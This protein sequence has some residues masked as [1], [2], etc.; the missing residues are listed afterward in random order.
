M[1]RIGFIGTGEIAAAMVTGLIG[2]GHQIMVS[3]R[4]SGMAAAL[5]AQSS[6]V[7]I[8]PNEQVVA[9]SD[10]VFLC[11]LAEVARDVL[12]GLPFHAGQSVIS[13][14]ADLPLADLRTLCAPAEELAITIPLAPIAVG[15][16]A[17]PVYPDSPALRALF[18]DTDLIIPC[19]DEAALNAHFGAS[20]LASPIL[21]QMR[22]GAAWLA[23]QTGDGVAA[24]QYV[25]T[26]FAGFLR[27]LAENPE[28]SFD[29]LL[30]SLATEGGLNATLRAHMRDAGAPKALVDGLDALKP[31]LG[32]DD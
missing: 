13:V 26:V 27:S 22:T 9:D 28:T 18:G 1:T 3:E 25:A 14:M 30:D 5:A 7:T 10:V 11:L 15:G 29:D 12:P 31:R 16:S 24:E 4:N 8:A 23:G 19:R 20:A 6:D 21:E 32:L 2:Q 17:L